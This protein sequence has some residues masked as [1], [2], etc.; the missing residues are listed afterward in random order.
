MI[1][2]LAHVDSISFRSGLKTEKGKWNLLGSFGALSVTY[3]IMIRPECGN[4]TRHRSCSYPCRS[5]DDSISPTTRFDPFF[6]SIT[7]ALLPY[8]RDDGK[9]KNKKFH[10][11]SLNQFLLRTG[12]VHRPD[13]TGSLITFRPNV[14]D[15]ESVHIIIHV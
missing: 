14:F 12:R 10:H 13:L 11:S 9:N 6:G 1:N 3:I 15:T 4:E 5:T 7:R 8:V 2:I